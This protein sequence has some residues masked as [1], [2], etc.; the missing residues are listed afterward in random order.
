MTPPTL[1]ARENPKRLYLLQPY[2]VGL[3][4]MW[5]EVA[6]AE[7][8][9][10]R[11]EGSDSPVDLALGPA[12]IALSSWSM[13][14]LDRETIQISATLTEASLMLLLQR[15]RTW[16]PS[17]GCC[18]TYGTWFYVSGGLPPQ[19]APILEQGTPCRR[20]GRKPEKPLGKAD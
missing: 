14:W 1:L 16:P 13:G 8:G 7:P 4:H 5:Q 3:P 15:L 20:L 6:R 11:K 19:R 18:I 12:C 17:E 2:W 9:K 10:Q